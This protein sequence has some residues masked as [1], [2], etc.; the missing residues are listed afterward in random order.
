MDTWDAPIDPGLLPYSSR[1]RMEL[2]VLVGRIWR[3][4]EYLWVSSVPCWSVSE[5]FRWL[6][7]DSRQRQ[8]SD[9]YCRFQGH[10]ANVEHID[11]CSVHFAHWIRVYLRVMCGVTY[12]QIPSVSGSSITTPPPAPGQ[13]LRQCPGQTPRPLSP[14]CAAPSNVYTTIYPYVDSINV[15]ANTE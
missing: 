4:G 12:W 8:V 7:S 3:S 15:V 1:V 6:C 14:Q 11:V 2:F 9:E 10:I 5:L 13:L